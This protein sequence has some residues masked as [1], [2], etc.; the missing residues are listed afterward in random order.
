MINLS[1]Y[2]YAGLNGHPK[3]IESAK[4]A[5]DRYGTTSSGVRL[6]NGTSDLHIELEARLATFLE[7]DTVVTYNSG[8][9]ANISA[10]AVICTP[11]DIVF[12]DELNHQSIV[13]GLQFSKAHVIKFPHR[14]Y[15]ALEA[16]LAEYSF[17]QRKFIITDGVFSMDGDVA[18]LPKTHNLSQRSQC[19]YNR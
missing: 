2:N 11:D 6:L 16:L 1:S 3:I 15:K 10:L 13:D 19:L 7:F 8:Y 9:M 14:D 5:L 18:D 4:I 17:E 12:S